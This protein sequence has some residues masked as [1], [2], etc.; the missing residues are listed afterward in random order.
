MSKYLVASDYDNTLYISDNDIKINKKA[1]K[2]FMRNK[3]V[4]VIS[5]GRSFMD[6]KIKVKKYKFKYDYAILNH[7]ATIID[8]NNNVLYNKIIDNNIIDDLIKDLKIDITTKH[9]CCSELKSRVD[10]NTLDLTKIRVDYKAKEEAKEI[11]DFIT[12]KYKDYINVYYIKENG[13]EIIS[14]N[15][16]KGKAIKKL[17]NILNFDKEFVYTIGDGYSDVDMIKSF[18]GYAMENSVDEVK[19]VAI[20]EV[21]SVSVLIQELCHKK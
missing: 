17:I 15:T 20:K 19:R 14:K 10:Y 11:Y 1:I 18:K 3:N 2:E 8:K 13:F 5:T 9:F 4:F 6:L 21:S 16:N 12:N 7:G